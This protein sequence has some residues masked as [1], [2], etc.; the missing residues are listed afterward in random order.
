M[1]RS[2]IWVALSSLLGACQ[3][4]SAAV[5]PEPQTPVAAAATTAPPAAAE[6]PAPPAPPPGERPNVACKAPHPVAELPLSAVKADDWANAIAGYRPE[7]NGGRPVAWE[8]A[9]AELDAYLDG[10]HACV[11]EA[12]AASFLRSLAA[13]PKEHPLSDPT[14][15]TT[16]ELVIDGDTGALVSSGVVGSSGVPEFDAAA[17][18]AFAHAF[19]LAKPPEDTLSSDGKLYVTW[20]LHRNP[21]EACRREQ[22]RPWKLRF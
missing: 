18:A 14:L 8:G 21:E 4:G 17:V 13:L 5:T 10:V 9:Q 20:E 15:E 7:A 2:L 22:A 1:L 12:F 19:P 6:S 16:L 11:H 3:A